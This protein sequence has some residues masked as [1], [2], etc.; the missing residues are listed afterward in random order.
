V[1]YCLH[2]LQQTAVASPS[3]SEADGHRDPAG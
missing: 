1:A 2:S 3:E